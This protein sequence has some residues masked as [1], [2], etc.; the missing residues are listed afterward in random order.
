MDNKAQGAFEYLLLIGGAILF[1]IVTVAV[2]RSAINQ[3]QSQSNKSSY[4]YQ[5]FVNRSQASATYGQGAT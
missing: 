5:L 2:L 4:D 1:V 3:N